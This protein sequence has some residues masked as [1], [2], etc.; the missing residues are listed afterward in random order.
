M[1]GQCAVKKCLDQGAY[2]RATQF[3]STISIQH[4]NLEVITCDLRDRSLAES[5]FK[6]IDIVLLCAGMV[7]GAKFIV[8]NPTS[9]IMYNLDL[10]SR[11]IYQSTLANVGI[12]GFISS[13][14]VYPDTGAP[15]VEREGF[16]GD[17][18]LESNY[19]NGWYHRYLET[20]CKHFHR[21]T[22]TRFAVVRPTALY[23]PHDNFSLEE[24][25]VI[26]GS[27]VK[28]VNQMNPYE[29]WGDGKEIRS[30]TYVDDFLD[31]FLLTIEKF[32]IAEPINICP[33]ETNTVY[34]AIKLILEA[35][36][37]SPSLIFNPDKPSAIRY[38]VSDPSK[39]QQILGWEAQ[40]NL[41]E[42]IHRTVE[43][44]QKNHPH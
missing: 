34:D 27:I 4:P 17:P 11:L 30:F 39:A 22:D 16:K 26:P 13:S 6:N 18:G 23:G 12:C 31:G 44:Y 15:N 21:T 42:G 32:A 1:I 19:G 37:F 40:V 2:V 38:K 33:F 14:Y 9:F 43:W 28:A 8:E 7:R 10:I 24:G 3:S 35:L 29:V 36:N 41:K 5:T 20:L 25:H